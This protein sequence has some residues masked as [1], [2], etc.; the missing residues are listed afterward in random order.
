MAELL[1][2]HQWRDG[3]L[4]L[5]VM[6][7]S[8]EEVPYWGRIKIV[9]D[10]WAAGR[11][12]SLVDVMKFDNRAHLR[13]E[14]YGW[15]WAAAAFFD[16]HPLTQSA[17]RELKNQTRNRGVEFSRQFYTSLR[18]Q[19]PAIA[20]DWQI[21]LADADY[22]YDFARAAVV[23]R[24][25]GPL[26]AGG[27]KVS[28]LTD[29]GWQST[30]VRLEAGR[31]YKIEASGRY[32]VAGGPPPWPCEAGGV[33]IRYERGR[34][35]GMLLGAVADVEGADFAATPFAQPVP[36]GLLAELTPTAS[37]TLYLKINEAAGGLADNQGTL[38]VSISAK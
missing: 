30:G 22:G 6:P 35:V 15:C 9:K 24:G 33:T 5:A 21:F 23:Q 19:W 1:A 34:P 36:I 2:T 32:Q 28:I 3:K 10:D 16:G 25:S 27:A 13:V 26:P 20:L 29:R 37:G 38:S 8:K 12:M 31:S 4:T 7:R 17:F 11:G 14:A 18:E